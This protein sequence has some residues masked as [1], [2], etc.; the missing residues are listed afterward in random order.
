MKK[1]LV[2]VREDDAAALAVLGKEI[3]EEHYTSILGPEQV[4][5]MVREFQSAPAV[6]RQMREEN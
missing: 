5:Y 2:R 4:E 3:W 6:L 1:R